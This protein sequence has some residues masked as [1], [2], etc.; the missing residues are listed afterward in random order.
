MAGASFNSTMP[1]K[2][3]NIM[4]SKG[5]SSNAALTANAAYE[6]ADQRKKNNQDQNRADNSQNTKQAKPAAEKV[7]SST[8]PLKQ[9]ATPSY[10]SS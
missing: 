9:Q 4:S 5:A 6:T 10:I 1:L 2:F 8:V 7:H 3:G